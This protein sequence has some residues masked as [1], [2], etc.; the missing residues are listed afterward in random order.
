MNLPNTLSVLRMCMIPLFVVAYFLSPV[1]AVV[2]FVLAAFTDF[3]DGYIARKYNMVTDLGK[4]LDPMADKVLVTAALFCVVGTNPLR[5]CALGEWS[6]IFLICGAT[7]IIARELLISA[8]RMIAAAKG[9]VVQA[10]VYGK[11]KTILQDVSLPFLVFCQVGKAYLIVSIDDN[12][13]TQNS[14]WIGIVATVLFSLAILFT[15]L[16]GVIY[17]V[18]NRKVFSD[19]QA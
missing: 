8:V 13:W 5:Y 1:W 17:L 19:K 12:W 15:I 9:I 3:L 4:L 2:V 16:S 6:G 7:V 14:Q 11:I 10:N 18:Q